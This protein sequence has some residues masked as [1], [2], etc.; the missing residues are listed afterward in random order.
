MGGWG[1][2]MNVHVQLKGGGVIAWGKDHNEYPDWIL[3]FKK[4]VTVVQAFNSADEI[5]FDNLQCNFLIMESQ[6]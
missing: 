5:F 4:K 2:G 3:L 6:E 1:G